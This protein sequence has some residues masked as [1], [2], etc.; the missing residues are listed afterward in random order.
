MLFFCASIILEDD[1]V[2][3]FTNELYEFR[4]KNTQVIS[5]NCIYRP[6]AF[7]NIDIANDY[8]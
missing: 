8:G 2:F 6:A 7:V 1:S 4:L 5:E 3:D